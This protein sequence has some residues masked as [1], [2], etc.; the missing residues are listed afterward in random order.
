MQVD[1]DAIADAQGIGFWPDIPQCRKVGDR[2]TD[3]QG[4]LSIYANR[5]REM[6][7]FYSRKARQS[8]ER[9]WWQNPCRRGDSKRPY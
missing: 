7:R 8:R 4:A 1:F 3:A 6:Q 2:V 9:S 5:R